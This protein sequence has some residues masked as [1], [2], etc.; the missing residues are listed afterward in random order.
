MSIDTY[1]RISR[2]T[3]LL[4][5][6]AVSTSCR[7]SAREVAGVVSTIPVGASRADAAKILINAYYKRFPQWVQAYGL[8]DPPKPVNG[9]FI[10]SNKK[11]IERAKS[12]GYYNQVNPADL[13]DKMP[14]NAFFDMIGLVAEGAHGNG[15]VTLFYDSH[16]NYLGFIA[17]STEKVRKR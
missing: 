10:E 8:T 16:T 15:A 5:L 3:I 9:S 14:L 2:L 1:K 11:V 17:D 13:L 4:G 12:T 7:P 6:A